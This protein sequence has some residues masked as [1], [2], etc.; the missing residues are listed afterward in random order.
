MNAFSIY[1][2]ILQFAKPYWKHISGSIACTVFYSFFSGVSIF[3]FIPLLD[4][5]FNPEKMQQQI[6]PETLSIP[7]GLEGVFGSL[8]QALFSFVFSGT[9]MDALL[10]ICLI[11]VL[12]FFFKNVFGYFQSF[13]MNYAE[14]G[15]IKDIRN[16]LYRHLHNLPLAYFSNERTGGLISRIVNDVSIINGGISAFFNTLI[17]EPLLILVY[18]SLAITLSWKLTLLSLVVFPFALSI[19]SFIAIKLHKE[20][21]VSQEQLADITSVLQETISGVKIVKAFGMEEFENNKF[22]RYTQYYFDTLIKITRIRDIAS[23]TT[24]L[25]SVIA[26]AVI[27]WVGGQQVLIE[28]SLRASEFLGFLFIIFQIMPPVKELTNVNN[29]IQES[30]AAG[31][32]IFE[33]LDTEPSIRNK[34]NPKLLKEFTSQIEFKNLSF[35]YN[36]IDTVLENISMKINK[37][38]VVAVVGS[39]GSGKTTLVDLVPRFYDPTGGGIEIDGIDLR[40]LD[41]KSLREKI[42]IVT[43]ETILFND[44]VKNNIAYGLDTCSED[45]IIA[46]AKAANA[47]KFIME[48]PERYESMIGER[49]VKLSGGERQRLSL[50]RAILKNPPILILDEA[51]SALDTESEI[52]V[53]EAIDHLMSG[54]TSIVIAHRLSTIQHATRIIVLSDGRIVETGTHAEL[55]TNQKGIYKKLYELQFRS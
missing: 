51:T 53:Q 47:H 46:A 38:E 20:R 6:T 16:A 17:R 37:G 27:I 40:E 44:S 45:K 23:P 8:K 48:M 13:M 49:G 9:Q 1:R 42:G 54:R 52:L 25:M 31:K 7:F 22:K 28:H 15:V 10:K 36:G 50:A 24:E 34:E 43:Q 18:L 30:S 33:I 39:S 29:R 4:I 26:G 19:I 3:L 55:I 12:S 21:G 41:V 2:R 35:T 11:I 14:E 5:L 32:R